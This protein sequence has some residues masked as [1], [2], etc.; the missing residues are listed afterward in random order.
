[1]SM[2]LEHAI[3]YFGELNENKKRKMKPCKKYTKD[4]KAE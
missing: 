2:G 4:T 1:M 3:E